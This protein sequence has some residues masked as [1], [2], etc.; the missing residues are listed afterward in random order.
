[1]TPYEYVQAAIKAR[2][3]RSA[4][5]L[6]KETGITEQRLSAWKA[7]RE[8]PDNKACAVLAEILQIDTLKVIADIEAQKA[9]NEEDAKFWRS[10]QRKATAVLMPVAFGF[11]TNVLTPTPA[12]AAP[13]QGLSSSTMY[14][15]SNCMRLLRRWIKRKVVLAQGTISTLTAPLRFGGLSVS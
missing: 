5:G 3:L 7:G 15:M 12:E 1:M 11:A 4:Y 8:W 14:I 13:L 9:K 6:S 10:V 2:G